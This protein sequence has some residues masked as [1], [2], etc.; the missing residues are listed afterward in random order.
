MSVESGQRTI[1]M[2]AHP[3]VRVGSLRRTYAVRQPAS[4]PPNPSATVS[5]PSLST[6]LQAEDGLVARHISTETRTLPL[7]RTDQPNAAGVTRSTGGVPV[8][9]PEST[10]TSV[11][12]SAM[13]DRLRPLLPPLE[14]FLSD[15]ATM[16]PARLSIPVPTLGSSRDNDTPSDRRASIASALTSLDT[17][18]ESRNSRSSERRTM[19][20][21]N[22]PLAFRSTSSSTT[23]NAGLTSF[24]E[25]LAR[26]E[27]AITNSRQALSQARDAIRNALLHSER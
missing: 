15:H 19:R 11:S 10:S 14:D 9:I 1:D 5:L 27:T 7:A 18:L 2:P 6:A 23:R 13:N 4:V 3:E 24:D 22:T 16:M 26:A 8:S 21:G 25:G 17:W 12:R 20:I